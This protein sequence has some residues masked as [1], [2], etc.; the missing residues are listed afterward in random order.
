MLSYDWGWVLVKYINDTY[1]FNM[2]LNIMRN[3]G[4][5]DV[6]GFMKE[7]KVEFEEKWREWLL[8]KNVTVLI[9]Q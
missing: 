8:N 1:G 4:S 3:C 2:I 5:S 9:V 7:D 6:I